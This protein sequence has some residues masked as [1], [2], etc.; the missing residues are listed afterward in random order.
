VRII[1][2]VD[3]CSGSIDAAINHEPGQ[4]ARVSGL[5]RSGRFAVDLPF[6]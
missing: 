1:T 2:R 6:L 3:D 4:T 5:T